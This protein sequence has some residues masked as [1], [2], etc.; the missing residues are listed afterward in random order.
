MV[1][2]GTLYLT[3]EW[4]KKGRPRERGS[5]TTSGGTPLRPRGYVKRFSVTPLRQVSLADD[6]E[7]LPQNKR[8]PHT[9]TKQAR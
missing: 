9:D 7:R 8:I 1:R 2:T 4:K 6:D 5:G 3:E